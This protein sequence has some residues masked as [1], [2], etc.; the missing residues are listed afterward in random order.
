MLNRRAPPPWRPNFSQFRAV[1]WEN[2]IKS[3]PGTSEGWRPLQK[4]W[5]CQCEGTSN[6]KEYFAHC[7]KYNYIL[8]VATANA[9]IKC[10]K[11]CFRK[12]HQ[13]NLT[14]GS[15]RVFK[16]LLSRVK[17]SLRKG[18]VHFIS[19]MTGTYSK[20]IICLC[21]RGEINDRS[22]IHSLLLP[23]SRNEVMFFFL[24]SVK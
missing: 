10:N 23:V 13:H 21:C 11:L 17:F 9:L 14:W 3:Y 18:K 1:F 22:G 16:F 19:I 24:L 7:E 15:K 12:K 2:L 4:S 6:S 20:C 8:F 5:V